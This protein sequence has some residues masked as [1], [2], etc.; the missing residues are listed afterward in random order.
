MVLSRSRREAPRADLWDE[1][2]HPGRVHDVTVFEA[3][4]V[5][6]WSGLLG[7]DG[8]RIEYYVGPEPIGF[9]YD[10]PRGRFDDGR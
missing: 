8:G 6:R 10:A 9:L 7:P 5:W 1:D 2:R 3:G 4:E